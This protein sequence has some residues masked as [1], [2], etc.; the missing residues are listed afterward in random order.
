[1]TKIEKST[2]QPT[3]NLK[4]LHSNLMKKDG[5]EVPYDQFVT[6]MQDENNLKKLH[7]NLMQKDG[8]RVPYKQFQTDMFGGTQDNETYPETLANTN[9]SVKKENNES[10]VKK[11]G[12]TT[13]NELNVGA[14]N[15]GSWMADAPGLIYDLAGAPFRAI[16]LKVPKSEDFKEGA[17]EQV[18][19]YY[20]NNAKAFEK[21]VNEV[22]PER[23]EGIIGSFK[24]GDI[25]Q[26]IVNLTGSISESLPASVAMMISGGAT[27]PTIL[28]SAAVFGAGKVQELD[29]NAPEM[30]YDKRRLVGAVNGTLEGIFETWLGSG[31]VG[32]SLAGIIKRKGTEEAQKQFKKSLSTVFSEMLT[33]NPWMAPLG[34][35]FEEVGTQISQNMVDKYSGYR[36]DIN[37]LENVG[38]AFAA[39]IGMGGLHGTVLSLAKHA[40]Q[41]KGI[42]IPEEAPDLP[43]EFNEGP[44]LTVN[45]ADA[46]RAQVNDFIT[47]NLHKDGSLTR[48]KDVD[49]NEWFV[50]SG[51]MDDA[52]GILIVYDP[53]SPNGKRA[54][55]ASDVQG[56]PEKITPDEFM[57]AEMQRFA[58]EEQVK[59]EI[60]D[61]SV[62]IGGQ[63]YLVLGDIEGDIG[64]Q[65]IDENGQPLDAN[66]IMMPKKEFEVA[67]EQQNEEHASEPMA[68]PEKGQPE[69]ITVQ[70]QINDSKSVEPAGEPQQEVVNT[71]KIGKN[72]YKYIATNNGQ[73]DV[74]LEEG[75]DPVEAEKEIRATLPEDQQHRVQLT[76]SEVEIPSSVPWVA[77]TKKTITTSI[78]ILPENTPRPQI[79]SQ[80]QGEKTTETEKI[81]AESPEPSVLYA[82][83]TGAEKSA[84]VSSN[85]L[86]DH[87]VNEMNSYSYDIQQKK[88]MGSDQTDQ[89]ANENQ[90]NISKF[91]LNEKEREKR[92]KENLPPEAIDSSVHRASAGDLRSKTDKKTHPSYRK[93]GPGERSSVEMKYS[94]DKNFV[95]D[96]RNKIESTDD[97]AYLFRELENRSIENM[98]AA[99]I[100]KDGRPFIVHLSMGTRHATIVDTGLL[101]DAVQRLKPKKLYLI[102]NHPSGTLM[103][104]EADIN[105]HRQALNAFGSIVQEHI[106]INLDSGKYVTFLLGGD[107]QIK[108]RPETVKESIGYNSYNFDRRV[109]REDTQLPLKISSPE[110]V[111]KFLSAQRFT[112]GKKLSAILLNRGN[113]IVAYVHLPHSVNSDDG[114]RRLQDDLA[115]YIGRFGASNVI[116]SSNSSSF[117]SDTKKLKYIQNYLRELNVELLD[118]VNLKDTGFESL[119]NQGVWE[120]QTDYFKTNEP[121]IGTPIST[122]DQVVDEKWDKYQIESEGKPQ[123]EIYELIKDDWF[124]N[125]DEEAV[126]ANID[127]RRLQGEIKESFNK[128]NKQGARSWMEIDKAIHLYLDIKEKNDQVKKYWKQ[129]S[130]DQ[131]R[132]VTIALS[133]T[134]EQKEIANKIKSIYEEVGKRAYE[135]EVIRNIHENYVART[136]DTTKKGEKDAFA[137]FATETGHSKLRTLGTIIEGWAKGYE[138]ITEGATNNLENLRVEINNVIENKRLVN[139]A[140]KLQTKE[141][142]PI[143]TTDY[144]SGYKLIEHPNFTKWRKV[145]QVKTSKEYKGDNFVITSDGVVFEK[146]KLYAP[147]KI[148]KN[149]NNILNKSTLSK[150]LPGIGAL[151]R[152]NAQLKATILSWS[153]FHHMAFIRSYML[154]SAIGTNIKNWTPVGAYKEGLG[155]LN[156][157][158]PEVLHLVRNGLTLGRNQE[159]DEALI[160]QKSKI[161]KW[162]DKMNVASGIREKIYNLHKSHVDFLFNKFG[163]GLKVKSAL[164]EYHH[165]LN[166]YPEKDP[167]YLAKL[168]AKQ[169]NADFGG[170]HLERLGRNKN[171]QHFMR[172]TLLAPDWTESNVQTMVKA[173]AAK[174]KIER[175]MYQRFW[176]RAFFRTAFTSVAL[177]LALALSSLWDEDDE[178]GY[179][180]EVT[181]KYKKAFENPERLN[182]LSVDVTFLSDVLKEP[183]TD[184]DDELNKY[185][186]VLGHFYDPVKFILAPFQSLKNKGSVLVKIGAEAYQGENWQGKRFT[187]FDELLGTD[188]KGVYK[189]SSEKYGF[190]VGDPKGGKYLGQLTRW[191]RPGDYGALKYEEIPSFLL[192]TLRGTTPVP[193]Q[194]ALSFALGEISAFDALSHGIGIHMKSK[195]TYNS[196]NNDY[197]AIVE[198]AFIHDRMIKDR[199][200]HGEFEEAQKLMQDKIKTK[201][202]KDLLN[203]DKEIKQLR[204]QRYLRDEVGDEDAS[205]KIQSEIEKKME[206]AI[207]LYSE[208]AK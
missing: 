31:A 134:D 14:N 105:I 154:G 17:L 96:G 56:N 104:S 194:N 191:R 109:F 5:F 120:L 121:S 100:D 173:F 1:M 19:D 7:Y 138:L 45:P 184:N 208:S 66:P 83:S 67:M 115:A 61:Q 22:N 151:T 42:I 133:L 129:L 20:K 119:A 175:R 189:T 116:L 46:Y 59:Q 172:L 58:Q 84:P 2:L 127:T 107:A 23:S 92:L 8:F 13:W 79:T 88:V 34:E 82:S 102:H 57:E 6:D 18:S 29:E 149:L 94:R 89:Y 168:V 108:Q 65:P 200:K 192:S 110:D 186:S 132:I 197:E 48:I 81:T 15:L 141:N 78:T 47:Q 9:D 164:L 180:D 183:G 91:G 30:N 147:P 181:E 103:P 126:K 64:L 170:L 4:K 188:D 161:G 152:I 111:A 166:K 33:K 28:G 85:A 71:V 125:K 203:L 53:N 70:P 40:A 63:P 176:K 136:W 150:I 167:D 143:L 207:K 80:P 93:L 148:A 74:R 101:A 72:N 144:I 87:N 86:E 49:N 196:I 76:Q 112:K 77:P 190:R 41:Q 25:Q 117:G 171:W 198:E 24:D 62:T 98:F 16:G 204:E 124:A 68:V 27:T 37:V 199:I 174:D 106:I 118:V 26:G 90:E 169:T 12:E 131:K 135:E 185:F 182:W 128:N 157:K 55:N 43:A 54:I 165:L 195:R 193:V 69:T 10:F 32:H 113:N 163:T 177:N 130:P 153:F 97:V 95:F 156:S 162:L 142:L 205:A 21:R 51:Q 202:S 11:L 3:A 50:S 155:L 158:N 39:G 44:N 38:D 35:G 160:D 179:W 52:D 73:F 75:Q 137:N 114:M 36:P 123:D 122:D 146:K 145:K 140:L 206:Y 187:S 60:K 201:R 159:W 99:L 139:L 178:K